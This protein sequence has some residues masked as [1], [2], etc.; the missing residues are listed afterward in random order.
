[1]DSEGLP[2]T[3]LGPGAQLVSECRRPH[4]RRGLAG[5]LGISVPTP[6]VSAGPLPPVRPARVPGLK[7]PP[8][9][10]RES[11]TQPSSQTD[12]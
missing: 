2:F 4:G 9:P 6:R 11:W 1:M 10:G 3:R 12:G 8:P 5:G 7:A